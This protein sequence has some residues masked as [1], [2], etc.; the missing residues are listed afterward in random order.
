LEPE[1]KP[2]LSARISLWLRRLREILAFSWSVLVSWFSKHTPQFHSKEYPE[3]PEEKSTDH[4]NELMSPTSVNHIEKENTTGSKKEKSGKKQN[5]LVGCLKQMLSR[6]WIELHSPKF[7]VEIL[8]LI[9]LV[10][11]VC[12]T[13]RTNN[14]TQQA[15]NLSKN[16]FRPWIDV[17][18]SIQNAEPDGGSSDNPFFASAIFT[19]PLRNLGQSPAI[20]MEP[21]FV[22]A[23]LNKPE[24][25]FWS[26]NLKFPDLCADPKGRFKVP[27]FPSV[28]RDKFV[29]AFVAESNAS[30]TTT[31]PHHLSGCIVYY[32]TSGGGP[33]MTRAVYVVTYTPDFKSIKSI[34]LTDI[35][36]E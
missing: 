1:T 27:V 21:H 15:V 12:E 32:G 30:Q 26:V 4:S 25:R 6:L 9:G 3:K 18:E 24:I 34:K 14:L 28:T 33:F 5:A 20:V 2:S 17:P 8:A 10:F 7:V 23:N 22:F 11:Y 13:R 29:Q 16:Q 36:A 31:P 19:L 35:Q